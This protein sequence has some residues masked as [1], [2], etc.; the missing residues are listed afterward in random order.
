[1]KH[2]QKL[3]LVLCVALAVLPACSPDRVERQ[4]EEATEEWSLTPEPIPEPDWADG[5]MTIS[6]G[7]Y[8]DNQ[9]LLQV[10]E[11]AKNTTVHVYLRIVLEKN[12]VKLEREKPLKL[13]W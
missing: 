13:Q 10:L 4:Q 5:T 3:A 9:H 8:D 7:E 2:I 6:I 12:L 11:Q 1:M